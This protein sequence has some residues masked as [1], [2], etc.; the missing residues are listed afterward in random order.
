[1]RH[2]DAM[3]ATFLAIA[4]L[5][6]SDSMAQTRSDVLA[7]ATGWWRPG[8][9]TFV[10]ALPLGSSGT[11]ATNRVP[12]GVGASR[13]RRVADLA[14]GS[15]IAGDV[16]GVTGTGL[17]IFLRARS[18]GGTWSSGLVAKRGS[19]STLNYNLFAVD[20]PGSNG[21]DIGF[22]VRTPMGTGQISFPVS[23]VGAPAW[24]D[25]LALYDGSVMRL[26]CN[27]RLLAERPWSGPLAGNA[28]PLIL[29]GETDLGSLV[30]PFSGELEEVAI[31]NR[32]LGEDELAQVLRVPMIYSGLPKTVHYRHPDHPIGDLR[33]HFIDGE[34]VVSYLYNPGT[35]NSA[36]LRTKDLLHW[37][38][39][40]PVH[41]TPA[42]G[43]SVPN[44]FVLSF[45]RD[46]TDSFW[47][48]FYGFAGMRASTS[49][50]LQ[51]WRAT[52]PHQLIGTRPALYARESDPYVFWNA[53]ASQYM[54][55]CTLGKTG[56]PDNQRGAVG[57]A[58]STDLRS[59]IWRGE[60]Y[61]PGNLGDPECPSM[62]KIGSTWYLLASYYDRA[63][64]APR[65]RTSTS[66]TGPW[67]TPS[68]DLLDGKDFCAGFSVQAAD[69]RIL[70]GWIPL[71]ASGPGNQFWGG[72]IAF[73]REIFELQ[74]GVL[75]T[76]MPRQLERLK[77]GQVYPA[78][79]RLNPESGSWNI[80]PGSA[81]VSGAFTN[82][83]ASFEGSFDR[84]VLRTRLHFQSSVARTAR[85]HINWS[86]SSPGYAVTID[87][88][89]RRL[90]IETASGSVLAELAL[91]ELPL[92]PMDLEIYVEEDMVEVFLADAYSL[93]AR[94]PEKLR[95]TSLALGVAGGPITFSDLEV[96][97][98]NALNDLPVEGD[99][100]LVR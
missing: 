22:E 13:S 42:P 85:V 74:S 26:Y 39:Q 11:V 10:P 38:Q 28:E 49:T 71:V 37:S 56:L 17:T 44:Y 84:P 21:S 98:F 90:A 55:I 16:A 25:I 7:G 45:L 29:G 83:V 93:C 3:A 89:N 91:R 82:G 88:L 70:F 68:L 36:I 64:G 43:Q 100:W 34:F 73:P 32:A 80:T 54:L 81:G 99:Q 1:M 9:P 97:Y 8:D 50:D 86:E 76:R 41:E 59:W 51:T 18:D 27:G 63:V 53:D 58:T 95:T 14:P 31:W 40:Q 19:V 60:L 69:Q 57:Y 47:T 79:T 78:L 48:T 12:T 96:R 35:W 52:T 46:P 94:L 5:G 67:S 23:V 30:R 61:I 24:L 92:Q 72:H 4:I 65:Y 20:L 6:G 33:P 15:F 62:F 2:L 75:A 77:G 87:R 66:A